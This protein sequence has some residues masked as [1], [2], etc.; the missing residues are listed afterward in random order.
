MSRYSFLSLKDIALVLIERK[1]GEKINF[2]SF[3]C[4][5]IQDS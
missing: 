2:E 1:T 5:Y 4:I 3:T